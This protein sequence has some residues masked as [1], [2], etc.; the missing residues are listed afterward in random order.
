MSVLKYSVYYSGMAN[1]WYKS[2]LLADDFGKKIFV[3]VTWFFS[4]LIFVLVFVSMSSCKRKEE[5]EDVPSFTAVTDKA[6]KLKS[7]VDASYKRVCALDGFVGT[8]VA[9]NFETTLNLK[10]GLVSKDEFEA[11]RPQ[12]IQ[13]ATKQMLGQKADQLGKDCKGNPVTVECFEDL[14]DWRVLD[15]DIQKTLQRLRVALITVF[16]WLSPNTRGFGKTAQIEPFANISAGLYKF[17]DSCPAQQK[18]QQEVPVEYKLSLWSQLTEAE[19]YVPQIN[20][21]LDILEGIQKKL[22]AKKERLERGELSDED[23]A[24]GSGTTTSTLNKS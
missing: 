6:T 15:K 1:V 7:I 23:M 16:K 17:M 2:N 18:E 11:G 22:K 5:F 3:C 8:G 14:G 4:I 12:R 13:Q 9:A 21:E 24:L 10:V 20:K 19:A